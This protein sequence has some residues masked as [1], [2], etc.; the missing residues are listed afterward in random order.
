MP[1]LTPAGGVIEE[2]AGAR[3]GRRYK[4][5]TSALAVAYSAW[6]AVVDGEDRA[7]HKFMLSATYLATS[8]MV[9]IF[10]S[11]PLCFM[12]PLLGV[13]SYMK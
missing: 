11:L 12:L 1:S 4:C 13:H 3:G 9:R 5:G 6:V 2:A 8:S 10:H 7:G